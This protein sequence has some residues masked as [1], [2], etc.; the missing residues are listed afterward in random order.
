MHKKTVEKMSS[1]KFYPKNDGIFFIVFLYFSETFADPSLNEIRAKLNL[2]LK[3]FIEKSQ[4]VP[5]T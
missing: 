2:L 5:E 3:L 1:K 4:K